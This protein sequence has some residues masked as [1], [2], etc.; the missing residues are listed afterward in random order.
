MSISYDKILSMKKILNIKE[1]PKYIDD[2]F[3]IYT[4]L[5]DPSEQEPKWK[6]LRCVEE[7]KYEM[8]V[9]VDDGL[10]VG[11]FI[12]D[13]NKELNYAILTFLGVSQKH[14]NQGIGSKLLKKAIDRFYM[15][16]D[17]EFFFIEA[18]DNPAK[19]Y[20]RY[21][22]KLLDM[23]YYIPLYGTDEL[24]K[25]NLLFMKKTK[26]LSKTKLKSIIVDI[27]T[28]GYMLDMDD[29]RLSRVLELVDTTYKHNAP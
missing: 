27:F 16:D 8:F 21:Q 5:F 28:Y 6:I 17:I 18:D 10:C 9:Y 7:N 29:K 4:S 13:I 12:V 23:E 1:Y 19:L 25:T 3:L 2:A 11:F 26:Q 24:Q 14:Q 20:E 15:M 22:F